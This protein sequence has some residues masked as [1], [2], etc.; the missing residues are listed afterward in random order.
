[1]LCNSMIHK[2][3][4][5]VFVQMK[6]FDD[7]M[8]LWNGGTLPQGRGYEKIREAFER[9]KLEVPVFEEVRGGMMATIKREKFMAIRLP[10]QW[11]VENH[12][13]GVVGLVDA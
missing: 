7:H 12:F 13:V 2:N 1:M 3:Y 6:V 4:S 8:T 5:G 10:L 9:E 11:N